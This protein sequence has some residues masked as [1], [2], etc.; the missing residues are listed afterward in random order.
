[1]VVALM[2]VGLG[3][4]SDTPRP[5]PKTDMR[6]RVVHDLFTTAAKL[7]VVFA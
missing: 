7:N 4:N 5:K 3:L 2:E 6:H 1:M